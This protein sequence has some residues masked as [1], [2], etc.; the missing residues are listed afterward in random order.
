[1]HTVA[2]VVRHV[3]GA[4]MRYVDRLSNRP[5]TDWASIPTSS[6]DVFSFGRKS[7]AA[8]RALLVGLPAARWDTPEVHQLLD[9]KLRLTPRKIVVHVLLHEIRHWAQIATV[10][11]QNG[12]KADFHDFLFSPALGG[13]PRVAG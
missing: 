8:L 7:R 5:I 3:F 13:D 4:E 9:W 6:A 11:R 1:M 10:L 2:D 12:L